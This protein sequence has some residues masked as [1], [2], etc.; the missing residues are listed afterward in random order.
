VSLG[1]VQ[2]AY[3]NGA[4]REYVVAA[5]GLALPPVALAKTG[6]KFVHAE[7]VAYD[8][9]IYFEANGHG[10][11]LFHERFLARL[12]RALA[13]GAG[14][15]EGAAPRALRRLFWA[16][17]LVNQAIGDALSDMLFAEAA[18]ALSGWGVARWDAI[19]EDRPSAQLKLKVRDRGAVRV[20]ADET[21]VLEPRALQDRIDALVA[22][23]APAGRAFLRPS[24]TEDIVRVYA[25]AADA[26]A[27]QRLAEGVIDAAREALA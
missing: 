5:A 18:L 3:A 13:A 22:R 8:V 1:V 2:T 15:G 19:Y 14:A 7:A 20:C 25:E 27:A 9:G 6:V 24:G 26:A 4:S 21:R 23:A 10:T 12:T 16:S 17:L 11:V